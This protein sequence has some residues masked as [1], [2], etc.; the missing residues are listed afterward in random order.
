METGS[1]QG[2]E[3]ICEKD[4]VKRQGGGLEMGFSNGV[5]RA[6]ENLPNATKLSSSK[7]GTLLQVD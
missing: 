5:R 2:K 1:T 4:T 7:L 3:H 6:G